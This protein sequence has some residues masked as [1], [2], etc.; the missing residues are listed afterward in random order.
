MTTRSDELI[1]L[2]RE[3]D[4]LD[5]AEL[6]NWAESPRR[7]QVLRTVCATVAE[8]ARMRRRGRRS[9]LV[10]VAVAAVLVGG[11]AAAAAAVLGRPAPDPVRAH[12]A[13]LDRGMPPDLRYNPNLDNA[14]AVAATASGALY[15]ADL[16]DGGYCI[17][18]TSA[19]DQP[20]GA[21]CLRGP[22]ASVRP[23]EV[24][25]PIPPNDQAPLLIGGRLNG[26]D[27]KTLEV[28]YGGGAASPIR[29]GLDRYFL[30]QVPATDQATALADGVQLIA[31]NSHRQVAARVPVPPLRDNDPQG[32]AHDRQQ[33]IYIS[34]ISDATDFTLVFGIEGQVNLPGYTTLELTYPDGSV[35]RIPT[36]THGGYNFSLPPDRRDDFA[37]SFGVLTARN[38]AGQALDTAPVGSVAAWRAR[39]H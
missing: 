1:H 11:A 4:P 8:P 27:L 22:Q 20:R 34:T 37:R 14:R 17:E 9:R 23:V 3:A 18:T 35:V 2:V 5:P 21:T 33:P 25:A 29:L 6:R 28:A 36:D 30:I 13:E 31:L 12:L 26:A 32:N 10:A 16:P 19:Y 24:L 7:E 39:N 15:A 38:A